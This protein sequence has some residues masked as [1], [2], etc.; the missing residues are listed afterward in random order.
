MVVM[1]TV[2]LMFQISNQLSQMAL[3]FLDVHQIACM[4]YID[5]PMG[6][7]DFRA[8]LELRGKDRQ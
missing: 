7:F 2:I 1:L 4:L 6:G 8:V 3:F 5:F